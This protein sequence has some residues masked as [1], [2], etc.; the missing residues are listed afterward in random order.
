MRRSD[1]HRLIRRAGAKLHA[2]YIRNRLGC[3]P[4]RFFHVLISKPVLRLAR[5]GEDLFIRIDNEDCE[6]FGWLRLAGIG[7]YIVQITR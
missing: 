2:I 5:N 4:R 1:S 7:T 6:K 3:S